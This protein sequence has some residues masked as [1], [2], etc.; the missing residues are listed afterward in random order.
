[1]LRSPFGER[2]AGAGGDVGEAPEAE[3]S[4]GE[5]PEAGKVGEGAVGEG[6]PEEG[7]ACGA[8]DD[9]EEAPQEGEASQACEEAVEG[10][11]GADGDQSPARE[12]GAVTG[13]A[14]GQSQG[15]G[16]VPA[17]P[18][19]RQRMSGAVRVAWTTRRGGTGYIATTTRGWQ[20][21]GSVWARPGRGGGSRSSRRPH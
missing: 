14:G 5:V 12:G 15:L 10:G 7:E 2:P 1:M 3:C 21:C 8:G 13:A 11:G 20:V 16:E 17:Q 19:A 4:G 6:L 9:A 18:G